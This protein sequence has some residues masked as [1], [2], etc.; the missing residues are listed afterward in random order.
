MTPET[1]YF[2]QQVLL[3]MNQQMKLIADTSSSLDN[4]FTKMKTMQNEISK[5]K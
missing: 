4:T 2:Q 3:L 1:F 5:L